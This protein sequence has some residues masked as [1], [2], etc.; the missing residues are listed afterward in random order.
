MA[1]R[2]WIRKGDIFC[3]KI[4]DLYKVFFQYITDDEIWLRSRV[5]RVF[6]KRYPIDMNPE[7]SEIVN[8]EIDFYAHAML[9]LGVKVGA[10]EKVGKSSNVGDIENVYFR[11]HDDVGFYNPNLKK[12]HRWY[13]WRINQPFVFIGDLTDEYRKY[14]IGALFPYTQ[15]LYRIQHGRYKGLIHNID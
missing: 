7:M 13:V 9:R 4:E 15:I 8:G 6:K 12:S 2:V 10:W 1:K 11:C 3:V 14:G 5:I